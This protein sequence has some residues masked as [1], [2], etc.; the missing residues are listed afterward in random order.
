M[1]K[2]VPQIHKTVFEVISAPQISDD[3]S[4]STSEEAY[5]SVAGSATSMDLILLGLSDIKQD[6]EITAWVPLAY[7]NMSDY[8]VGTSIALNGLYAFGV[9]GCQRLRLQMNST[10]G[11]TTVFVR[12]IKTV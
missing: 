11:A 4:I 12:I 5:V 6:K 2:M 1:G 3:I 7:I 8:N 10:D 9:A